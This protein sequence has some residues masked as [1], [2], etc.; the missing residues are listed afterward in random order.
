[1]IER[2]PAKHQIPSCFMRKIELDKDWAAMKAVQ[3]IEMRSYKL[4]RGEMLVTR[5]RCGDLIKRQR[6][7]GGGATTG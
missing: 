2:T 1:M 7:S 4:L 3:V 6:G 5:D